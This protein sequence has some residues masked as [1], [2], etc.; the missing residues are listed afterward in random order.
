MDTA[1][2][3]ANLIVSVCIA[4]YVLNET[5]KYAEREYQKSKSK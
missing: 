4:A 3:L 2:K 5:R 1:A